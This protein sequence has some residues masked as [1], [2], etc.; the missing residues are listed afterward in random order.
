[1][2][3]ESDLSES[4][5]NFNFYQTKNIFSNRKEENYEKKEIFKNHKIEITKIKQNSYRWRYFIL[6]AFNFLSNS[7]ILCRFLKLVRI[8]ILYTRQGQ[9]ASGLSAFRG[10]GFPDILQIR[11]ILRLADFLELRERSSVRS[12]TMK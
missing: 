7:F 10:S 3:G 12:P 6:H 4:H 11:G 8:N 1:M 5:P 2:N 9:K